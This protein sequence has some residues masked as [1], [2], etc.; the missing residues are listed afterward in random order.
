M[1][2]REEI[3]KKLSEDLNG[4]S[5]GMAQCLIQYQILEALVDIRE[6]LEKKA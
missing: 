2:T 6:L 5:D 1:R 3:R 4:E